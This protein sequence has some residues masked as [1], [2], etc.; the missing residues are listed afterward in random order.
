[1]KKVIC[2]NCN[3][4]FDKDESVINQTVKNRIGK[5]DECDECII[6]SGILSE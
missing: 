2:K 5:T 4:E 1:M 6:H 3:K